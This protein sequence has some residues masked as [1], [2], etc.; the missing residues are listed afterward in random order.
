[1]KSHFVEFILSGFYNF[2]NHLLHNLRI[3]GH[4]SVLRLAMGSRYRH[5]HDSIWHSRVLYLHRL[6]NE[7]RL[8]HQWIP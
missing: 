4:L 1:M 5:N 2:T 8:A 7:A 3:L 6:E